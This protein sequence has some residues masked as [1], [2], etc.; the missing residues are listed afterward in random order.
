MAARAAATLVVSVDV[1]FPELA[2]GEEFA[3]LEATTLA[4]LDRFNSHGI[5]A[6]WGLT[7]ISHP[8]A[9]EIVEHA[10]HEL[11]LHVNASVVGSQQPRATY[12]RTMQHR[13]E[14]ARRMGHVPSTLHLAAD[15]RVGHLDTLPKFGISAVRSAPISP[16]TSSLWRQLIQAGR[17][18]PQ[19][20]QP[21]R[22]RWGVWEFTPELMLPGLT[23]GAA[24]RGLDRAIDAG[25][26]VQMNVDVR[27]LM[28]LGRTSTAIVD[29]VL[30][31]AARRCAEG[32]LATLAIDQSVARLTRPMAAR[33]AGSILRRAA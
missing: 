3:Q 26:I 8:L 2:W 21:H 25:R 10:S 15:C 16:V 32:A 6:T 7:D 19:E 33:P 23:L 20:G 27:A 28:A 17:R 14:Q 9:D 18:S 5:A 30:K 22:L 12:V 11:A 24:K 1:D 4:L 29:G 13:L 31:H